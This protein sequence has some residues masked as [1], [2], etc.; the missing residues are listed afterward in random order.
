MPGYSTTVREHYENVWCAKSEVL[1][2]T[3][4]PT[5]ELPNDFCIL[6]FPPTASKTGW[7]YATCCMWQEGDAAGS[8]HSELLE[9]HMW[10][11]AR[12]LHCSGQGNHVELLTIVAHFHRTGAKLGLGHTVN[13][14]RPWQP[15]SNCDYGLISLPYLDGPDLEDLQI[16]NVSVRCLWLIPITQE[17]VA[18]K[19]ANGLDALEDL[20]EETSFNYLD[21]PPRYS[22]TRK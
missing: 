17:E 15:Q 19:R 6:E 2:W 14:G 20:F 3:Q 10:S 1:R 12:S 7:G 21:A 11:P 9:L 8:E 5:H 13:F 16:G 18:F 22:V 4:G